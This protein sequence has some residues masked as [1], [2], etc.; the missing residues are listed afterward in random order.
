MK[1]S[2]AFYAHLLK[3]RPSVH[4][5]EI[6]FYKHD[7]FGKMLASM[8]EDLTHDHTNGCHGVAANSRFD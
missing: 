8:N 3:D 7:Q 2:D 4:R 1:I 6:I 5:F